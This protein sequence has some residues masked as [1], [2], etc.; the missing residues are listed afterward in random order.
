MFG[1]FPVGS[2]GHL[3]SEEM[4]RKLLMPLA[5]VF[6]IYGGPRAEA[7]SC[8]TY[9]KAVEDISKADRKTKVSEVLVGLGL[10]RNDAENLMRSSPDIEDA[11]KNALREIAPFGKSCQPGASNKL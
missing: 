7:L 1:G 2:L 11:Q 4:M 3:R 8:D 10:G 6:A 5:L 9:Q